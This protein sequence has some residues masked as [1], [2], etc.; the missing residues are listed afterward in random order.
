MGSGQKNLT[1]VGVNFL[2]LGLGWASLLWFGFEFGKYPLKMSNFRVK[3]ISLG[4]VKKYLLFIAG[5]K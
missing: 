2:W 3:K 4:W 5:Q 1:R